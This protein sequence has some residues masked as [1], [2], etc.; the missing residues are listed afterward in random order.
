MSSTVKRDKL[1]QYSVN[2]NEI[3]ESFYFNVS[4]FRYNGISIQH[5]NITTSNTTSTCTKF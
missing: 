1:Q 4:G 2:K 5:K 3:P